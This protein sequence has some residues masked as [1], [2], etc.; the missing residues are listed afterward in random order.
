MATKDDINTKRANYALVLLANS[1]GDMGH[2][3]TLAA[4]LTNELREAVANGD[5]DA[6]LYLEMA[7]DALRRTFVGHADWIE[8]GEEHNPPLWLD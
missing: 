7:W 2:V 3:E 8:N 4:Q 6:D 5:P 1:G